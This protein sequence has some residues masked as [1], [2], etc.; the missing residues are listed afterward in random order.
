M[1][2]YTKL[3]QLLKERKMAWKELCNSG[4]AANSPQRFS[5]NKTVST[6]TINKVCEYLKVQPSEIMEWIPDEEYE[7]QN[8]EKLAIEAKIAALQAQLKNMK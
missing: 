6:E 7:K 1:I 5:S 4:I 8:A 3:A 2:V